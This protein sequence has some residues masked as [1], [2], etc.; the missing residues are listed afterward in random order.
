MIFQKM[1][2]TFGNDESVKKCLKIEYDES[3]INGR[4]IFLLQ[5]SAKVNIKM[6][7]LKSA[8]LFLII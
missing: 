2:K 3:V 1:K 4:N 8:N 6:I 5:T 7:I